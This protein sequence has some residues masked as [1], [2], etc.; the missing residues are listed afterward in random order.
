MHRKLSKILVTGGAGFIGSAF[1]RQQIK[2][3]Y[4][5]IVVDK[6]TY[7]G[8]LGRLKEVEG[9]YTFYKVDICNKTQ[10]DSIFAKERPQIIVNFSAETHVDRSIQDST[11]F[12]QTNIKGTQV[13]LDNSR[14]YKI[15]KFIQISTDEVYGSISK[16]I[17]RETDSLNPSSPYASSKAA[18]DLLALSY[19]KT[20]RLPVIITR[21]SNNFGPYQYPEKIIPLFITNAIEGKYL[22]LYGDG[23]NVRDWLFVEDN[24]R[25]IDLI[26]HK[27]KP[28]E[29]YNIGGDSEITNRELANYIL[30]LMFKPRS[31]IRY[32]KDRPGHDHRYALD[33]TKIRGLG[34]RP[35]Y[36]FTQALE[37]SI[38]WYLE[39][40]IWWQKVKQ[41]KKYQLYYND[42]YKERT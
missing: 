14:K 17:F 12:I 35:G 19:F 26:I 10:V 29:I 3:G 13:L 8:D 22:P 34:W 11:P 15:K 32:V 21:S 31:L 37:L 42:W 5:I 9:E 38:K 27:G 6:L 7:A 16:G 1:V 18:G 2:K 20:Y 41:K 40:R 25:A 33:S 36:N 23:S 39:S 24:C 30:R 28:G 4:D